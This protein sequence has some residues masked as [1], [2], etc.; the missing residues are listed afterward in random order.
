MEEEEEEEFLAFLDSLGIL[1][2]L[3]EEGLDEPVLMGSGESVEN[4]R[5]KG[6]Q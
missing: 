4:W 3:L 1:N 2:P 6:G 5:G